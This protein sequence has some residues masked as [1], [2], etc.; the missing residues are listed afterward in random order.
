[1][2]RNKEYILKK[3]DVGDREL[4]EVIE[5]IIEDGALRWYITKVTADEIFIEATLSLQEWAW[6]G[7]RAVEELFP[8]KDVVL[9]L[10]PTG[11]GC[12]VGGYA[13]DAAP[14]TALLAACSDYLITNP[15]AV[16]ASDFISTRNNLL[17]TEGYCIDL[18]CRGLVNLYLPYANK[19]GLVIEKTARENL[20]MVFNIINTARAVYGVDIEAYEITDE[21]IGGHCVRNKSGAYVGTI[22]NPHTLLEACGRLVEKGVN[23]IAVTSKLQDMPP[24]EYAN[25]FSGKHPNPIGGAEAIISHLIC[26]HFQVPAAHAPMLNYKPQNL[27]HPVVDARGAGEMVSAS[28]L[29]C[30]LIGLQKAPQIAKTAVHRVK[31]IVNLNNLLAIVTP[32][33][34]LG[35]IPV[36][37]TRKYSIPVIAVR[38]N[39][40]I[41]DVD[42]TRLSL[43]NVIEVHN[44]AEAAGVIMAL[45][46]GISLASISRP[47]CSLRY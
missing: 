29:A 16:N 43:E 10:I 39:G 28:G 38:G 20:D 35:G 26:R 22:D 44:Y 19:V 34:C 11:V 37:Y 3:S 25:H 7:E 31:E 23:A 5:E 45:R 30:V 21:P 46:E 24:E 47:L 36:L 9:N 12:E 4:Y 2:T 27:H 18:F 8:G 42:Q 13:G 1:M 40:T 41:L 14:A 6:S 32:A 33:T 15:N 17:Y